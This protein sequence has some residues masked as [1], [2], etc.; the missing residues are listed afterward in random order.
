MQRTREREQPVCEMI[1]TENTC[2]LQGD[3]KIGK[4]LIGEGNWVLNV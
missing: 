4:L 1:L 2:E 3:M